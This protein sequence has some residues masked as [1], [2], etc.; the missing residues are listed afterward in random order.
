MPAVLGPALVAAILLSVAGA[1]KLLDP[2]MTVGALQALRLPSSALLV[3][4]GSAAELLI[5]V[6]ALAAG[7]PV[8]WALVAASY[9]AFS[10]VVVVALRSGSPLGTCGCF[11]REETP[12]HVVHVALN[13]GLATAAVLAAARSWAGFAELA[14]PILARVGVV[15]LLLLASG[16]VYACYVEIPRALAAAMA[17]RELDLVKLGRARHTHG[18]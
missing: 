12:P 16:L 6:L 18:E 15:S 8:L 14:L 4:A 5:G 9:L 3:R 13:F 1:Q 11:G 10:V 17:V 2:T 7:G